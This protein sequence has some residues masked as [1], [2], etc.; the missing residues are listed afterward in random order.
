MKVNMYGNWHVL[1]TS[2]V[3]Y[4]SNTCFTVACLSQVADHTRRAL[5]LGQQPPG[6][7]AG[8]KTGILEQH[9]ARSRG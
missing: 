2:H 5:W 1:Y 4:T 3:V 8:I 7:Y 9:E 6:P